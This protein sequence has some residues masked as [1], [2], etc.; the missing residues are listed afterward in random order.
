MHNSD[1]KACNISST[2]YFFSTADLYRE[3]K[4]PILNMERDIV[5]LK[6]PS[7]EEC[8]IC[9]GEMYSKRVKTL[10]CNH[11]FHIKCIND[12]LEQSNQCPLC[13]KTPLLTKSPH[14]YDQNDLEDLIMFLETELLNTE[15]F[16][17]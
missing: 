6:Y 10:R 17:D 9:F 16:I 5:C 2:N 4:K 15:S 11:T 1:N 7:N 13:R 14:I 8:S 3:K 12:W